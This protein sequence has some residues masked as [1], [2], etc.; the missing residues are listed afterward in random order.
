MTFTSYFSKIM[1]KANLLIFSAFFAGIW[2]IKFPS[3]ESIR[4]AKEIL[5]KDPVI[6]G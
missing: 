3:E 5:D 6:D 1:V 4:R 2:G